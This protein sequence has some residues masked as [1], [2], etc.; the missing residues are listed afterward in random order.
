[1]AAISL[2][3]QTKRLAAGLVVVLLGVLL[4]MKGHMAWYAAVQWIISDDLKPLAATIGAIAR[5]AF[6]IATFVGAA[7]WAYGSRYRMPSAYVYERYSRHL[8]RFCGVAGLTAAALLVSV[9]SD[10]ALATIR[11][12]STQ[13]SI[14]FLI[15][16]LST[17]LELLGAGALIVLIRA[18]VRRAVFTAELQK[19]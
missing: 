18:L 17:A 8:H 1:L 13:P 11:L 15:P 5:Y 16:I 12:V 14:A 2:A 4:T 10:G 6:W 3:K 7:G 9:L 19:T